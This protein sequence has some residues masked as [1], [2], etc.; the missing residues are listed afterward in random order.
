MQAACF[1]RGPGLLGLPFFLRGLGGG[2][3]GLGLLAFL[4]KGIE[5]SLFFLEGGFGGGNVEPGVVGDGRV[6]VGAAQ[7]A[8]V[9]RLQLAAMRFE[10]LDAAFLVEQ[11]LLVGDLGGEFLVLFAQ[12]GQAFFLGGDFFLNALELRALRRLLGGQL[13]PALGESFVLLLA[14]EAGLFVLPVLAQ[15]GQGLAGEALILLG[16]GFFQRGV[17]FGFCLFFPVDRGSLFFDLPGGFGEV[18]N[19]VLLR[20]LLGGVVAD[21]LGPLF[22]LLAPDAEAFAELGA[23]RLGGAEVVE[24]PGFALAE[25]QGLLRLGGELRAVLA[26]GLVP[27]ELFG[28]PRFAFGVQGLEV[29]LGL[30]AGGA[31]LLPLLV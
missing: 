21:Q 23:L 16:L 27:G 2:L 29:G 5:R 10:A 12:G 8:G 28:L 24:F 1:L 22:E 17:E 19:E 26:G 20:L 31:G 9:A 25:L 15:F 11:L 4:D 13:A 14:V 18:A 7:R 3:F 6:F 30:P